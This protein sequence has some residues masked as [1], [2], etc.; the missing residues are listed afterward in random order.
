[1]TEID[2]LGKG[3]IFGEIGCMTNLNRTC[4]VITKETCLFYTFNL[5]AIETL[6]HDFPCI[7]DKIYNNIS[8]YDD[9]NIT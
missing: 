4:T 8:N 3:D 2:L 5:K 6:K 9:E 1:M 7:Y